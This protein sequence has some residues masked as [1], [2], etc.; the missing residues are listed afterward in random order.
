MLRTNF[1]RGLLTGLKELNQAL[2]KTIGRLNRQTQED[3]ATAAK[4]T[5][6]EV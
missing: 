5:Q 1:K 3:N 2:D 4:E 6:D